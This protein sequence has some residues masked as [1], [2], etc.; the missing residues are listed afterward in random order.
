MGIPV[1]KYSIYSFIVC[2]IFI[3]SPTLLHSE[4]LGD[5]LELDL[6]QLM[7]TDLVV[8]SVSKRPQKLHETASAIYV[9][10]Q[11]DIR[12][13]G[14][15]NLMEALRIVPGLLV[16][17]INQ[18]VFSISVRGFNR[19]S[20]SDKLLVLIDGRSIY[21]PVSNGLNKGVQWIVQDVVLEDIDRIEVI[22]GPGAALWG[23]NAVAGGNSLATNDRGFAR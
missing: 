3:L 17:K 23:S 10:T 14:A 20:G 4:E 13:T 7:E 22:R 5:I 18:N 1:P 15:V 19:G 21:S 6:Y 8:T 12:R 16:S 11:E 9:V 2:I